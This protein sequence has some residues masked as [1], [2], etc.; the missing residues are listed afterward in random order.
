MPARAALISTTLAHYESAYERCEGQYSPAAS[1]VGLLKLCQ[2]RW[3]AGF[4]HGHWLE[5]GCGLGS[6]FEALENAPEQILGTDFAATACRKAR[7]RVSQL[8][9]SYEVARLDSEWPA[10]WP[11]FSGILDAHLLH[12]LESKEAVARTLGQAFKALTHGGRLV[13]EV[14]VAHKNFAPD[15][16][17][18]YDSQSGV[19]TRTGGPVLHL[20]LSAYDWEQM[21]LRQGFSLFYFEV[22]SHLKFIHNPRRS[23]LHPMDPEVLRFV[24]T[25]PPLE[26]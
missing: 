19:L 26:T 13:G 1:L 11:Q 6:T 20:I 2:Q 12:C 22:Y 16:G 4:C 21:I 10:H 8:N 24:A 14:M 17:L 23:E 9:I 7:E 15:E 5:L 18:I 3:G 25:K